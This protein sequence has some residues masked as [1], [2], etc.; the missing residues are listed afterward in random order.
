MRIIRFL[1]VNN[2]ICFGHK[3]EK[4]S[5]V[6]LAGELFKELKDTGKQVHVKK[7]LAPVVPPAIL[8]IG[9]NYKEHAGETG[10]KLPEYPVLFMKNPSA[11]ANPE[12]PIIIPRS[13]SS[14]PEC[15]YEIE[16]AVVIGRTAK[17][18]KASNALDYVLGY[19]V[20]NDVSARR[21]QMNAGSSQWVRGKSFDTFCPLGPV[22]V[23]RDDI[24][25]PQTLE[26]T[27]RL[28]GNVMQNSKTSD[29]IF[30][31]AELI[32]YLSDGTTLLPGTVILSGT[33]GGV[34]YTRKPPVYLLPGDILELTIDKIGTLR[35]PVQA[36]S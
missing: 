20:G 6:L 14:K 1:D 32:A 11:L 17:N 12:D 15:D 25:D 10:F 33:P 28:N 2:N 36:E 21:W 16:L 27:C 23:T 24:P 9:L 29:M 3:F 34:G 4:E 26:L 18:V 8:C 22:L 19:T 30:T 5:A 35:N 13:C 31:V 7:I